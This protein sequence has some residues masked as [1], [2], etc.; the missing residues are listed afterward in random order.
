M[1][2]FN[3]YHFHAL[4]HAVQ[5]LAPLGL[6]A[7][8]A[9]TPLR[10]LPVAAVEGAFKTV[11]H[12]DEAAARHYLDTLGGGAD[13]PPALA[14]INAPESP[15]TVPD[16]RLASSQESPLTSTRLLHFT[17]TVNNVPIMGGKASVELNADRE[18]VGIDAHIADAPNVDQVATLSPSDA[19]ERIAG[20]C[21]VTIDQLGPLAAPDLMYF[22]DH[23][24]AWHLIYQFEHVVVAPKEM[25]ESAATSRGHGL[26]KSPR[27]L[28]GDMTYLVDAHSGEVVLYYT[29]TPWFTDLPTECEGVDELNT[30]KTFDGFVDSNNVFEMRDPIRKLRTFDLGF[31]D[32][33]SPNVPGT[34]VTNNA[35]KFTNAT[36]AVSA[37]VNATR[38][39][40][41]Y[42]D[43]L[44]RNGVDDNR[45]EVV[46]IV[47]CTYQLPPG[48]P[49][50][51]RNAVWYRKQMLYGQ[52]FDANGKSASLS[53]YLDVIAHELTHGVT[54]TTS[55][56]KYVFESGAL[57]E[58][59]SDIFGVIIA[60]YTMAQG[61]PND[62]S[63]WSWGIGAGLAA[64]G[65][66]PLRDFQDPTRTGD[67]DHKSK[68]VV[69][70]QNNDSGG[71]HTNS[72]IHNKAAYNVLTA[73]DAG[74]A[75][76]FTVLDVARLYYL[77]LTRLT[78]FAT[79]LDVRETL[80]NVAKTIW[81]GNPPMAQQKCDA[82][83]HAYDAV[84]IQ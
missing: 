32:I 7:I 53:R 24:G 69:V 50:S 27:A 66:G 79:F 10:A 33:N 12:N 67:P 64:D 8:V 43:H 37:H 1:P 5:S 44:K 65:K 19:R 3:R 18:L 70:S 39:F 55:G 73:V 47:N 62:L 84:G 41:F 71:V 51:W 25:Q 31:S 4:D 76:V 49:A 9:G 16:L 40:D 81:A 21:G 29:S 60:N 26:D 35:S 58:S 80:K 48:S 61:D 75:R 52:I 14:A 63:K 83:D 46:S 57:N 2:G 74:G 59:F 23:D 77:T 22:H 34:L 30:L 13:A 82:I 42:N 72:N 6:G 15:Q 78:V 11:F 28:L 45:M 17:Q 38:V 68:Y 20:L 54:E 56:L 36:A